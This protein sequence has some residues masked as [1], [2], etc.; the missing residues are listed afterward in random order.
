MDFWRGYDRAF[1]YCRH[2]IWPKKL[3]W[4]AAAVYWNLRYNFREEKILLPN[5]RPVFQLIHTMRVN[6][7]VTLN[8]H[9]T[10]V[11]THT[12]MDKKFFIPIYANH[13][14]FVLTRCGWK[15]SRIY[16]H[17]TF[18]QSKVKKNHKIRSRDKTQK[19]VLNEKL[20]NV[21]YLM[22]L[23]SFPALKD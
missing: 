1:F 8:S 18:E 2:Q 5:E 19:N 17:Y 15:V 23:K 10:T 7:M 14:H 3:Q 11:T 4:K 22:K 12:T 13:L 20:L 9:K 21:E 16:V 6:D